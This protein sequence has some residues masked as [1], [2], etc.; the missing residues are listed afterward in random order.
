M[1]ANPT[2]RHGRSHPSPFPPPALPLFHSLGISSRPLALPRCV[3]VPPFRPEHFSLSS[4]PPLKW[5]WKRHLFRA[6]LESNSSV[7]GG[8]ADDVATSVL[9]K[10]SVKIPFGSRQ[11]RRIATLLYSE[12]GRRATRGGRFDS[13]CCRREVYVGGLGH[14]LR[15]EDKAAEGCRKVRLP[16][17]NRKGSARGVLSSWNILELRRVQMDVATCLLKKRPPARSTISILRWSDLDGSARISASAAHEDSDEDTDDAEIDPVSP[18]ISRRIPGRCDPAESQRLSTEFEFFCRRMAVKLDLVM[19]IIVNPP[20]KI[21]SLTLKR[22]GGRCIM[23]KTSAAGASSDAMADGKSI[24]PDEGVAYGTIVQAIIISGES[25]K[26]IGN[27]SNICHLEGEEERDVHRRKQNMERVVSNLQKNLKVARLNPSSPGGLSSYIQNAKR[28]LAD[29]KVGKNPY[30]GFTPSVLSIQVL[31]FGD[32]NFIRLEE[33][34]IKEAMKSAFV[35]VAGGLGER[36]G[37]KGIKLAF[38]RE[39]TTGRCFIQHCIESIL[40]LQKSHCRLAQDQHQSEIPLIMTS[41]DAHSPMIKLLKSNNF[42]GMKSTQVTLLK[43]EKLAC[44]DDNDASFLGVSVTKGYHVNSLAVPRKAK[45]AIGGITKLTHMDGR[46]IAINVEYNHMDPLLRAIGHADGDVN[47]ETGFSPF[48]GNINQLILGFEPYL[49]ELNKTGVKNNPEDVAKVPKGNPYHIAISSEV[50]IY[51][52]NNIILKKAVQNFSFLEKFKKKGY[53]VLFMVGTIL[54]ETGHIGRQASASVTV[55][56]GETIVHC[57]VCLSDVPSEPSDFF[58]LTVNYQERLSAAGRTSGGYFKREGRAKDHEVLICRLIDRPLRPTMPKGFYHETQILSWVFS[59][60][61]IHSPDCLSVTAAGIAVA[62]SEVPNTKI[63]AG[64]RIGLVGDK[65]IVNPTT[66]EMEDSELDLIIAGTDSAILMIEVVD[67]LGLQGGLWKKLGL[68]EGDRH[69]GSITESSAHIQ[70]ETDEQEFGRRGAAE[71]CGGGGYD[72]MK[73]TLEKMQ[74][75]HTKSNWLWQKVPRMSHYKS[76]GYCNFLTEE[77]LLEALEVGQVAIREICHGAEALVKRC[78]KQKMIEAI[79]LPPN[80]LYRHVEDIAGDDLIKALQIKHKIPR[81]RALSAIEENVLKVLTEEGYIFK[82]DT[83]GAAEDSDNIY[84]DE[85]EDDLIVAD[86]EV[87]EGDVHIKPVLRRPMPLLFSEVDVKLVFKEVSSNFLRK[88]IVEDGRRSDGRTPTEIR[89]INSQC[90]LLPRAHGSALFTRGETQS[91]AVVTLGDKQMAQ[92]IDNLVDTEELKRFYLQLTNT[93]LMISVNFSLMAVL[94]PLLIE[95]GPLYLTLQSPHYRNH[96][97]DTSVVSDSRVLRDRESGKLCLCWWDAFASGMLLGFFAEWGCLQMPLGFHG[98]LR[99]PLL[100]FHELGYAIY[101][102]PPSCVGEVGRLGAPSRREV[103]H[104]MLAERA[105]EPVLPS[106]EDFPYT[107]RVE[108][109]ITESNGSSSMA[110]VCGG[111]LA[112]LD[113]GVPIKSSVAGIA[114]GMVMDTKEFG[115]DGTPLILSDITGSEDASGDMDFK[116]AG[117]ENGITAFQMD[118][119]VEGI[120]LPVM[121]KALIQARNGRKH[122]LDEMMKSSPQ[123][124]RKL[125]KYAPII[126]IMKV[127]PDK[128]NIII[129]TGGKKVKSIIEDT[130]VDSI[131][132]E[133]NGLIKI[134]AKDL[135]SLEKSKAIIANLTMVPTVGDIYRGGIARC[136]IAHKGATHGWITVEWAVESALGWIGIARLLQVTKVRLDRNC[137]IKSIAPYG[138]FVE[139]APGREV[140]GLDLMHCSMLTDRINIMGLCHISELS[141]TWLA[142]AEDVVKV[143][144]RIDVKL[145]EINQKGHLRLSRRALLPDEDLDTSGKQTNNSMKENIPPVDSPTTITVKKPLRKDKAGRTAEKFENPKKMIKVPLKV[146]T[147]AQESMNDRSQEKL[148]KSVSP[149]KDGMSTKTS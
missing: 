4:S 22:R 77:K 123:P 78:G 50:A 29:S 47:C 139:I 11:E 72:Y 15:A 39:T 81:R 91:L 71:T 103:G 18:S 149:V 124:S 6:A 12:Q 86:G 32:D 25:K 119:K 70:G 17:W 138:A 143:G 137:E 53:E 40:A 84:V 130:G 125:S 107:I 127:K 64:V 23:D 90:G 118:I 43:Q 26:A 9:N 68:M 115:G 69:D 67:E 49:E 111:C 2:I 88:R 94:M 147:S 135:S 131:D 142:N 108:S 134:T 45:E 13:I 24:N 110:S 101:S 75:D 87:D 36:L 148:S 3:S 58:P 37:Y 95:S 5:K 52:A 145:I 129:G 136:W 46:S 99:I 8:A 76:V 117:D 19:K 20:L 122:V 62:L 79:K 96:F 21:L 85:E 59:Y 14:C 98:R 30:D 100:G 73:K 104:G 60:D 89:P 27:G 66:K 74:S 16:L 105:I 140:V 133:E 93:T 116:V 146:V 48:P 55:T 33:A 112:L 121:Q 83:L 44:L 109:T 56:D 35:L 42:F 7:V 113:A 63:I 31:T 92:R 82:E 80:D 65:F 120:T 128:L 41:D 126:H 10:Y 34:G 54:V 28:L 106:E 144:D 141:S 61:G 51:K 1:L 132:T 114:M 102:F 57:S 97:Y 38:P